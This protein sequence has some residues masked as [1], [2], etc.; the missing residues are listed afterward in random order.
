MASRYYKNKDLKL[1]TYYYMSLIYNTLLYSNNK[2][3]ISFKEDILKFIITIL[4]INLWFS[5]YFKN[6][7]Y[8]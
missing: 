6:N 5:S 8:L 2:L 4:D 7:S 3:K 1:T